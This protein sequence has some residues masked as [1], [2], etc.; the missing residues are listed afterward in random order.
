MISKHI[1]FTKL[2]V[3]GI[4][5]VKNRNVNNNLFPINPQQ[6][7]RL[8][9]THDHYIM[10]TLQNNKNCKYQLNYLYMPTWDPSK[11]ITN[12]ESAV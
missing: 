3:I 6:G 5:R 4:N 8:R 11:T 9:S 2:L 1:C 12:F 10:F 7:G